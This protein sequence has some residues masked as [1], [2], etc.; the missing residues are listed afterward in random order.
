MDEGQVMVNAEF[1]YS[2]GDKVYKVKKA[3]LRMVMEFQRKVREITNLKDAA[4]ELMMAAY[5][6]YLVLHQVDNSISEE[7]V[8]DKTPGDID[9]VAVFER[10]GFMSQQKVKAM[11]I[12]RNAL[13]NQPSGEK[14]SAS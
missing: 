14:S 8:L 10:L 13:V 1:D 4:G 5:A 12:L 11:E 3:S 6:I 9:V 2:F 7:E